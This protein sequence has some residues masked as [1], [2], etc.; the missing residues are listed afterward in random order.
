MK[1]TFKNRLPLVMTKAGRFISSRR[2]PLL[3][4]GACFAGLFILTAVFAGMY[5]ERF[6]S[7]P[8]GRA[9]GSRLMRRSFVRSYLEKRPEILINPRT[10]RFGLRQAGVEDIEIFRER[11][12]EGRERLDWDSLS[13]SRKRRHFQRVYG[14]EH[15]RY[16]IPVIM[17]LPDEH[18]EEV[19]EFVAGMI[20]SYRTDMNREEAAELHRHLNSREGRKALS[21]AQRYFLTELTPEEFKAISPI[22]DE[23]VI[24]AAR[25]LE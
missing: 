23:I 4:A 21:G 11:M 16:T 18:R 12:R 6:F 13:P 8:A 2:K 5:P 10:V 22:V 25:M 20:R 3:I 19:V 24:T 15:L 1:K 7:N 9:I 17:S 14:V